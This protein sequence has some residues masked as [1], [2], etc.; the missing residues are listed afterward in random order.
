MRESIQ[1]LEA[2]HIKQIARK[3]V[4]AGFKREFAN[5]DA[6]RGVD[7]GSGGIADVPACRL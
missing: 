5:G 7:I 6:T 3:E 4:L 1:R 2:I